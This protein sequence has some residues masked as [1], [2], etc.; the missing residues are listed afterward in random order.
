VTEEPPEQA[1]STEILTPDGASFRSVLGHFATG[2]T[3]ITAMDGDEPVGIA[4][5]SRP[6]LFSELG[7]ERA[8]RW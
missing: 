1:A 7:L 2:I 3:V 4:A 6:A 5:N 8:K